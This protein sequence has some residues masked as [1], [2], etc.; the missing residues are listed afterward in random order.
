MCISCVLLIIYDYGVLLFMFFYGHAPALHG[1]SFCML[2]SMPKVLG[3]MQVSFL[4]WF[5]VMTFSGRQ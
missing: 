4:A 3:C 1:T 2:F 5:Q